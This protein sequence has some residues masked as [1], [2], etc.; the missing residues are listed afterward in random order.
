[1]NSL[2]GTPEY[3]PRPRIILPSTNL[4]TA[5][6]MTLPS[7]ILYVFAYYILTCKFAY[8]RHEVTVAPE[9]SAHSIFFTSGCSAKTLLT[10]RSLSVSLSRR[11]TDSLTSVFF[12]SGGH[13]E[14]LF[15]AIS[16]LRVQKNAFKFLSTFYQRFVNIL[17][18]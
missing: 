12:L 3:Q 2:R 9:F 1:M 14:R 13:V 16:F 7:L 8:T 4:D 10:L 5:V 6:Y 11:Y 18:F 17:L 15:H